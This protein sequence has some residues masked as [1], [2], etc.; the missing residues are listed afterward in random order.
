LK[1]IVA[2]LLLIVHTYGLGGS[3]I[4][5]QYLSWQMEKFYNEQ[6]SKGLYDVHDLKEIAIPVNM[7]GIHDWKNYE[8]IHGQINFGNQAYNYVQMRVTSHK[9]YLKCIPTYDETKLNASN[10]LHTAPIKGTP[11]PQK[12]HVPYV[13]I[14][15]SDVLITQSFSAINFEPF[16]TKLASPVAGCFAFEKDRHIA[17]P[18]QPPKAIC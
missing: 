6:A 18:K 7:P 10:I 13:G 3:L 16:E 15:F 8:N 1:K 17:M 4:L 2:I 12:E 9:L 5:H 11:V 14:T